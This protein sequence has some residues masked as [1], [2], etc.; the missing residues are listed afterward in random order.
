MNIPAERGLLFRSTINHRFRFDVADSSSG[1]AD[2]AASRQRFPG[3]D[4]VLIRSSNRCAPNVFLETKCRTIAMSGANDG[5]VHH[6]RSAWKGE[7]LMSR[8]GEYAAGFATTQRKG[9]SQCR[10][11]YRPIEL[12][13]QVGACFLVGRGTQCY[14]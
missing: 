7:T 1:I 14:L 6:E 5:H 12:R 11:N 8:C 13:E 9:Y 10:E 4:Y 3:S 2:H